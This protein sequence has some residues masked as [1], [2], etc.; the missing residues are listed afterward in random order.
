MIKK[1]AK[2]IFALILVLG[3]I[4]VVLALLAKPIPS[5]PFF[6]P[7]DGVLVMAHQGGK[8]L[9]P[10]NTMAAFAHAWDL[11]S[12][13]LEMDLHS[14]QDG[15]LLLMHD[16][17]VDSTTNGS[18]PIQGFQPGRVASVG[19]G[20]QLDTRPGRKLS[21]QGPGHRGSDAGRSF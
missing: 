15:V 12:D 9:R 11:G 2:F 17:T 1:T 21:I 20:L 3:V 4:Y 7:D 19:C 18:G 10:D 14:S 13:V 8:G 6:D 5:H 16:E